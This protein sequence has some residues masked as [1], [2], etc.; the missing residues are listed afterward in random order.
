MLSCFFKKAFGGLAGLVLGLPAALQR[1]EK[2]VKRAAIRAVGPKIANLAAT[3]GSAFCGPFAALYYAAAQHDIARA[4]GASPSEAARGAAVV[5][6]TYY[7]G[8]GNGGDSGWSNFAY[9]VAARAGQNTL[10]GGDDGGS[11]GRST[12]AQGGRFGAGFV[13][14]SFADSAKPVS[15]SVGGKSATNRIH[16]TVAA[17][18]V[19]G[20]A[21]KLGGGKFANGAQTAA[22]AHLL[23]AELSA[24]KG[25]EAGK[26]YV[27]G[28][29]VGGVGPVHTAIEYT[30]ANGETV[31]FSAGPDGGLLVSD[32]N[33]SSDAPA[34]N[35]TV[36]LVTLPKGAT[37]Q[38]YVNSLR[39]ADSAY[40][41]CVDYDLFPGVVDSFNSNSYVRGLLNA[42][43]GRTSVNLGDYYGGNDP[44]PRHHFQSS[45]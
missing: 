1:L 35:F 22:F 24:R 27:T 28:H 30:D 4:Y 45:P 21:S 39:Q 40:C 6:I 23:N 43:G 26:V 10:N 20:T 5:G 14:S 18:V 17:A 25:R 29:N 34:N 42:T 11:G 41:D 37:A 13:T 32:L 33:R 31:T 8:Q 7:L 9:K 19:G 36:D 15:L 38:S 12:I 16:R 2:K 3:I 44:L